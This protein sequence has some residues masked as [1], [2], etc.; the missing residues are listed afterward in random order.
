RRHRR[1]VD[2]DRA[3]ARRDKLLSQREREIETRLAK[4]AD[5]RDHLARLEEQMLV[6][7]EEVSALT[8]DA[9]RRQLLDQLRVEVR[10]S[11]TTEVRAIK[12]EIQVKAEHEA[13]KIMALAMERLASDFSA[14]RSAAHIKL[15]DPSLRGRII[16]TEGRNIRAFEKLTGMQLILD[17]DPAQVTISGFN[18]VQ[19]EIARRALEKLVQGGVIHPKKIEQVVTAVRGKVEQESQRAGKEAVTELKIKGMHPEL[20][21]LLGRL[22]FRTSYGQAVLDHV[23]EVAHLCGIMAAELGLDQKLAQRAALLHDIGK[24]VDFERE[25]THPEIGGELGRRFGEHEVVINS[26]E[27]HHDD[28][29]VIH[30]ISALV[31]AADALS[32][33]RPGA[34]RR[35]TVDYIRRVNK[36]EEIGSAFEGVQTCY[37]VQAGREVRV[38]VQPKKVSDDEAALLAHDLSQRIQNEVDYPGRIKITVIRSMRAQSTA[39]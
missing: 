19:R 38:I 21:G 34:R 1:L 31:A 29:D 9:A 24:A 10:Q 26:I 20:V 22:K 36:L 12:E 23:K 18:P 30:P 25:G 27:S 8:R 28:C 37:A 13:Q 5:E 14:Q 32:G 17:D 7:L 39:R 15:S 16:G 2:R 11:A 3:L 6:R 33:A 4:L 35:T